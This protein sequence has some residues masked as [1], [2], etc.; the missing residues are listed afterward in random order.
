[1]ARK[2][3]MEATFMT[4]SILWRMKTPIVG[5]MMYLSLNATLPL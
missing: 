3:R 4:A 1:M 2:R 5:S